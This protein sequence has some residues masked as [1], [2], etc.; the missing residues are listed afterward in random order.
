MKMKGLLRNVVISLSFTLLIISCNSG[1]TDSEEN[2]VSVPVEVQVVQLDNLVQSIFYDGDIFAEFEVDVFSKIPDRIETY[3]V[4][5]GDYIKKGSPIARIIAT[6]IE[7]SVRQTEAALIAARA[8]EA[9]LKVE[10]ERAQRLY[11]ENATSQQQFDLIKTQYEANRA[12]VEQAEAALTSV[13]SQ[14]TDATV[15]APISGIIGKRYFETGDMANLMTPL[16][17]IMQMDRLKIM[18]NAIEDDLGKLAIGQDTKISVRSHPGR[19][20][21]GK[22]TKISPI[23]DPITRMA[24]VE[25]L[26]EN[27]DHILKPG[28]FAEVEIIFGIL[29]NVIAVPRYATIES[30]TMQTIAG[31]DEVIKNY[32]VYLVNNGKAVQTKLDVSYFN[33]KNMAVDS[34]VVVGDT[35]VIAGQ[36]NLRDG[37]PVRIVKERRDVL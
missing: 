30:T 17:K 31:K 19:T 29:E 22:V 11:R 14:F 32:Y 34:A 20:F 12:L 15:S 5:E 18:V 16:V 27:K 24:D 28:M 37:L 23:L 4:D 25:I 6:T 2:T 10:F 36:N 8:Q 3:F 7:Q 33:H 9:N 35:L 21:I 26:L 1:Q 13:R